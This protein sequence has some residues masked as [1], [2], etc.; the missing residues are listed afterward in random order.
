MEKNSE[1]LKSN[2]VFKRALIILAVIEFIV[3]AVGM[4]Y[5]VHK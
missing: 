1:D 3:T 2:R 5:Y 4:Y